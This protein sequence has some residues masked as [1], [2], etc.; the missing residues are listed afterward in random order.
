MNKTPNYQLNQWDKSDRIQMEDFN[1]DN[2]K[3]EAALET[4]P[5]V[6][7]GTYLGNGAESR[8]IE[9][10]FMPKLVYVCPTK[11]FTY[12][13]SGLYHSYCGGLAMQDTPLLAQAYDGTESPV[14][15]VTETGFF[16]HYRVFNVNSD[17]YTVA[18][19]ENGVEMRYFAFG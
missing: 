16:V 9:I 11:G 10:G 4:I 3:I 12:Y 7:Y 17:Q 18:S 19:N 2:A 13:S 6:T 15:S 5:K 1:A 14:L 8:M